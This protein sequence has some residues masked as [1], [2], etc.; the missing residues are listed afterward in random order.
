MTLS[1]YTNIDCIRLLLKMYGYF[2]SCSLNFSYVLASIHARWDNHVT[3]ISERQ[4]NYL[5]HSSIVMVKLPQ[6]IQTNPASGVRD[7]CGYLIVRDSRPLPTCLEF[8]ER[9]KNNIRSRDSNFGR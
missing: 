5:L 6:R 7:F 3:T 4:P 1:L 2:N 9:K 8:H